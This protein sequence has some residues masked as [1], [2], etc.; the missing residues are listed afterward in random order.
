TITYAL[1]CLPNRATFIALAEDA[2]GL[3]S[4]HQFL[5]PIHKLFNYLDSTSRDYVE[6]RNR[7]SVVRTMFIAQSQFARKRPLLNTEGGQNDELMDLIHGKWLDP[8]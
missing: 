6:H 7:L 4:M 1:F 5:L 8:V 3:I 2:D